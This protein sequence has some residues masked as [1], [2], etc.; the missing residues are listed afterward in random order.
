MGHI[1]NDTYQDLR[2]LALWFEI[3]GKVKYVE[4]LFEHN[5]SR[6]HPQCYLPRR[7][8]KLAFGLQRRRFLKVFFAIYGPGGIL[9][10]R[11]ILRLSYQM[12]ISYVNQPI[13]F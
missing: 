12:D 10:M 9:V 5:W 7:K 11:V 8:V 6:S 13:G 4:S 2:T 3:A 1:P